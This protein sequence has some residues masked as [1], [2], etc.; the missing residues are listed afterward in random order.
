MPDPHLVA[1]IIENDG[2][3][4]KNNSEY[5]KDSSPPEEME[6]QKRDKWSAEYGYRGRRVVD[7]DGLAP[8]FFREILSNERYGRRQIEARCKTEDKNKN[9]KDRENLYKGN[10]KKCC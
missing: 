7:R 10:E 3:D 5:L 2:A 8:V 9:I 6:Q 1:D 4:E